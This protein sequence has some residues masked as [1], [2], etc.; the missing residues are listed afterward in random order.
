MRKRKRNVRFSTACVL[1]VAIACGYWV[2]S[3]ACTSPGGG[4][5]GGAG[6][7]T[8]ANANDNGNGNANANDNGSANTNANGSEPQTITVSEASCTQLDNEGNEYET[9]V[10]AVSDQGQQLSYTRRVITHPEQ[11]VGLQMET[12]VTAD[13]ELVMLVT[14]TVSESGIVQV[15]IDYGPAVPGLESATTLVQNGVVSGVIGGRAIVPMSV[16]DADATTTT[17]DDGAPPPASGV[18]PALE[19]AL[20]ELF[21]TASDTAEGCQA[22]PSVASRRIPYIP[23]QDTG[24]DS[25][26]EQSGGCAACWGG[27]SAAAVGCAAGVSAACAASLIFYAVCEAAA[28]GGCAAA[29]IGCVAGCNATG[30][31]CCPVSCGA[32]ACCDY[33]ETCL[34]STIGLCCSPGKT[35]CVGEACCSSSEACISTG[36]NAGTCCQPEDIC[37][38]TCCNP[39][40]SCI[41]AANLCCP[42]GQDPCDDKCCPSG[43]EC[44]GNGVCCDPQN[45]CGTACCDELDSCIESLSLCCGFNSPACN[46]KCCDSGEQCLNGTTCCPANRA[47][48]DV[49]CPEASYCE[50]T[51]LTCSA[52]PNP[53]DTPCTVGGCCPAGMNCTDF[54]GICCPQGQT[55]CNGACHPISECIN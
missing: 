38:N 3:G 51:T 41:E 54:E 17:F 53:T 34:D 16:D 9:S 7:G 30:A 31:P 25:D 48:G 15:D 29:Y 26:P 11:D 6:A 24:H 4:G 19:T 32:V 49:C 18:D 55:Y 47:C 22:N 13:G 8:N 39:T 2:I 12:E 36:P 21:Q 37:G 46:N 5:G 50:T 27:C 40:D 20:A 43:E 52:C 33:D 10:T 35:P 42:A 23:T 28:L 45:S 44:L 1:A 14:T